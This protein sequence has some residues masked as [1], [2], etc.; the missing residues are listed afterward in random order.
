MIETVDILSRPEDVTA[1]SAALAELEKG[2]VSSVDEVREA[3]VGRS[4]L[5]R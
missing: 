3:M 2:D 1:L 5:P 4:R